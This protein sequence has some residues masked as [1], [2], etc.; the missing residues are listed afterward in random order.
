MSRE[1][2]EAWAAHGNKESVF[3]ERFS[4]GRYVDTEMNYGWLTW[5][6]ATAAAMLQAAKGQ[7][8]E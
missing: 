5:Q 8:H 2:F 3:L 7:H 4:D 6:A 1:A